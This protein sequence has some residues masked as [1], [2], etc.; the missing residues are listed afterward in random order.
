MAQ[1][2]P[3]YRRRIFIA[4]D[5]SATADDGLTG[6]FVGLIREYVAPPTGS[7]SMMGVTRVGIRD[8]YYYVVRQRGEYENR[9]LAKGSLSLAATYLCTSL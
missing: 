8:A 5:R 6:P 1:R 4:G 9:P 3:L 7:G 2:Q